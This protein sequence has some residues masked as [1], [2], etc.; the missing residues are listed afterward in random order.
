[1]PK[2]KVYAV[3]VGRVPGIY[4]TWE[5]TRRQVE[6]Y[7]GAKHKSFSTEEEAQKYI[8]SVQVP[9]CS[10]SSSSGKTSVDSLQTNSTAE[11]C[12]SKAHELLTS[13]ELPPPAFVESTLVTDDAPKKTDQ[14]PQNADAAPA[15]PQPIS[16]GLKRRSSNPLVPD[17][18]VRRTSRFSPAPSSVDTTSAGARKTRWGVAEP[19]MGRIHPAS[20]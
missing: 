5:E 3:A 7:S 10:P 19:T 13:K 6:K 8:D 2:P 4:R 1:M 20:S 18:A 16:A 14:T 11:V 12:P 17:G 15:L 9:K